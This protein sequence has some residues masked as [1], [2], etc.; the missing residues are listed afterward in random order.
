MARLLEN[1]RF[2]EAINSR[3]PRLSNVIRMAV[4]I[5]IERLEQEYGIKPEKTDAN[6][7]D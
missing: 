6:D 3:T 1:E 2:T 5:G 4:A 7:S